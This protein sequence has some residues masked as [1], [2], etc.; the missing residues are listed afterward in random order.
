[1]SSQTFAKIVRVDEN[2]Y[3]PALRRRGAVGEQSLSIVLP[4]RGWSHGGHE[5]DRALA[6]SR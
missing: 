2:L 4:P 5:F 6:S 3:E 1:M